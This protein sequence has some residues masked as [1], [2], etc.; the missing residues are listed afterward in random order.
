MENKSLRIACIKDD[1]QGMFKTNIW[2]ITGESNK[3]YYC[4]R[5]KLDNLFN[6]VHP[7]IKNDLE[8]SYNISYLTKLE[9]IIYGI[10]D[11][12]NISKSK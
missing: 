12:D 10:T 4:I 2:I 6:D 11:E 9:S 3:S 7:I 1:W 8:Q 5:I